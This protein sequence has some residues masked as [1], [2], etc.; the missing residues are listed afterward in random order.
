MQ[1]STVLHYVDHNYIL[2]FQITPVHE[3][4]QIIPLW[5]PGRNLFSD[6]NYPAQHVFEGLHAEIVKLIKVVQVVVQI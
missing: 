4:I 5:F 1:N 2:R 3:D 6:T